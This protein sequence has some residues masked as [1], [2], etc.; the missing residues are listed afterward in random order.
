[1]A[2]YTIA[3]LHLSFNTNKPMDIFGNNW[4]D[5]Q[6]K[7]IN[8]VIIGKAITISDISIPLKPKFLFIDFNVIY[9]NHSS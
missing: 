4:D 7:I 5:H 8:K 1:M 2:I 3:D 9:I 6:N